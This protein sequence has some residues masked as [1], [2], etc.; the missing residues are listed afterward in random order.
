MVRERALQEV[1]SALYAYRRLFNIPLHDPRLEH[2]SD[3]EI[4]VELRK[5]QMWQRILKGKDPDILSA[6]ELSFASDPELAGLMDLLET[7][8]DEDPW[9]LLG[10]DDEKPKQAVPPE[11]PAP[12]NP[13]AWEEVGLDAIPEERHG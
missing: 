4:L 12:T 13:E 8:D 9:K 10:W 1:H 11:Q 2:L 3:I 7:E 5:D 6:D